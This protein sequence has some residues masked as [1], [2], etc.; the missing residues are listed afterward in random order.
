MKKI[1]ILESGMYWIDFVYQNHLKTNIENIDVWW[2][3][4]RNIYEVTSYKKTRKSCLLSMV[5]GS[6]ISW[7]VKVYKK[8]QRS[9]QWH[10][11]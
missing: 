10:V 4:W 6:P 1:S 7:P 5:G 3:N 9:S 2:T 11:P 8:T